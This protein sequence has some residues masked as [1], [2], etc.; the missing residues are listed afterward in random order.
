MS[1]WVTALVSELIRDWVSDWVSAWVS[2]LICDWVD[3]CVGFVGW[4]CLNG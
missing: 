4:I 3:V 2:E 1:D